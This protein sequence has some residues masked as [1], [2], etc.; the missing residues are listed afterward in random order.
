[1][2]T[3][4]HEFIESARALTG[5]RYGV[6]TTID[7]AGGAAGLSSPPASR[8]TSTCSSQPGPTGRGLVRVS[9]ENAYA[10][11]AGQRAAR[12]PRSAIISD[13]R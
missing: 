12:C 10:K 11:T 7:A 1:M 8:R 9:F 4:L 13:F 3:V 6:I 2:G 5:A